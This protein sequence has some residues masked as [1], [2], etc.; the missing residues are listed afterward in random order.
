MRPPCL[1]FRILKRTVS[2]ERV[3]AERGLLSGLRMRGG[4]LVGA[5]PIHG[6][7]NVNAFVVHPVRNLWRC[8][9]RCDAGGDIVELVRRLDNCGYRE[10]A[11]YLASLAGVVLGYFLRA[12]IRRA[13]GSDWFE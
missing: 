2:L 4:Q 1:D 11:Y 6:G 7:D 13:R 3:L 10:V 9:T 12:L 8:F 5:C